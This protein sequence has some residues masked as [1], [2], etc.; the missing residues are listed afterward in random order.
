[1]S[2]HSVTFMSDNQAVVQVINNMSSKDK[3]MMALLRPLVLACLKHNILFRARHLPGIVNTNADLLS[4]LKVEEFR[5]HTATTVNSE[6]DEIPQH[7]LPEVL[8]VQEQK[9][10]KRHP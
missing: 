3:H 4:R 9:K 1:M 8:F 10:S 6:P 2:N 7:L 5:K